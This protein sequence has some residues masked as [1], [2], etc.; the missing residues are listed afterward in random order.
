MAVD[1]LPPR[2]GPLIDVKVLD[3]GVVL[4]GPLVGCYL[5]DLGADVVKIER[6]SGDPMRENGRKAAGVSLVWKYFGR[7][8]RSLTVDF[9]I[10]EGR[11]RILELAKVADIFVENFRPGTL[12]KLG[13]GWNDLRAVNPR[14]IMVRISG[15]GQTGP[16]SHRP[17]FG[18]I[19]ESMVGYTG[20]NGMPDGPPILPP[21]PLADTAA[22]LAASLAALAALNRRHTTGE[23]EVIDV[24]LLE[25]LFTY[26]GAQLMEYAT[27]G[28]E[29][30]RMGNRLGF[31]S[32]RG[33]YRCS[34][35]KWFAISGATPA[36]AHCI[37]RAIGRLDVIEDPRFSSN[38]ARMENADLVDNI[39]Q[40]WAST[41]SRGEALGRLEAAGAPAAPIYSF[42]DIVHDEHFRDRGVFV[43]V[44]DPELGSVLMPNVF[45]KLSSNPGAIR[46]G[47]RPLDADHDSV[48]RDWLGDDG[49]R[50]G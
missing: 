41:L 14:L 33:A 22:A 47:G 29:P 39:I 23:G 48:L 3:L 15:F 25:P 34:D 40:D 16:Y 7:N 32:P 50:L 21:V 30:R 20:L 24:S 35:D 18:T 4:A 36:T 49:S 5:G 45:A 37:F 17:G 31:A 42:E 12:E 11:T 46:F 38:A 6:P 2:R 43:A 1:E 19:A 27:L 13:L 26:F 10:K 44:P 28:I 9:S 8:K